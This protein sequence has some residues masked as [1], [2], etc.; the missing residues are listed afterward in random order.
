MSKT[1]L[2]SYQKD[3]EF[4]FTLP[5][6][7]LIT[8]WRQKT[9]MHTS[10]HRE[11]KRSEN[12]W[13]KETIHPPTHRTIQWASQQRGCLTECHHSKKNRLMTRSSELLSCAWTFFYCR[14]PSWWFDVFNDFLILLVITIAHPWKPISLYAEALNL[15]VI[16][17]WAVIIMWPMHIWPRNSLDTIYLRL[18]RFKIL[19]E[20]FEKKLHVQR[21]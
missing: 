12:I 3:F 16:C 4:P 1:V 17:Q 13:R 6:E 15:I 11:E 21:S 14:G 2:H 5:Q 20:V 7:C 18:P 8:R 9:G 10:L 19:L